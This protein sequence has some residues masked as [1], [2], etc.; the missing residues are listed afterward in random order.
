M[1]ILKKI[2]RET[3]TVLSLNLWAT[4][5]HVMRIVPANENLAGYIYCWPNT[6]YAYQLIVRNTYDSV[7][8]E[9]NNE[10]LAN[11]AIPILKDNSKQKEINDNILQ[12]NEL[13]HQAYLE[14]Q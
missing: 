9:I 12:A 8:D 14:E 3:T 1:T 5:Q 7:V 11:V 2:L 10:Q 6:D 13:R 4:N